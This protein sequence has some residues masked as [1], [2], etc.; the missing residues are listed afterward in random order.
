MT[1]VEN[2]PA[3]AV[4][5]SD[6]TVAED[7]A[8][9]VIGLGPVFTDPDLGLGDALTYTLTVTEP[10]DSLV[11]QVSQSSYT[12]LHQDLQYTH[13]GDN[14]GLGG[15]E[16]DLAREN[17]RSYFAGLGLQTT[18]EPFTYN[19]QTY[20]NVVGVH[21]GVTPSDDIYLVGAHY[22]SVN[23]PGAD[24]NASGTA[25]VMELARVLCQYSF[26]A[27]LVFVAFDREEQGLYG[28][29]AYVA[30]HN[31]AQVKG[32]LS[33]DMIAYNPAGDN[34]DKVRFYDYNGVGSIK[35]D[36]AA[37]FASYSGGLAT[38][39]SNT[40]GGSDHRPFEQAGVDAALV[41][42]YNVWTNPYYH[43]A[44]DAVETA[45]NIDYVYATQV[46]RGVLG[47]LA[48]AAGCARP[49]RTADGHRQRPG[50]DAG[51][52]RQQPRHRGRS[53]PRHGHGWACT[54]KT[55]SA[56]PSRRSTMPPCWTTP[57]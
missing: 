17:I 23:N 24:D 19:S 36:L 25:A 10:V 26:D 56:S 49:D 47:Y 16:H 5:L 21:P 27:T 6:V 9:T 20:Y 46:T 51:L 33:L 2:P 42:E 14:R 29:Y 22:D 12:T 54:P 7:A 52:R 4:P 8:D 35:S 45:G 28:S 34:H 1:D 41:I 39:D 11:A 31:P 38:L 13:A 40:L 44:T 37:A 30:A 55:R 32:M 48:T 53:G 3:V 50:L 57:A 18:L 15:W 43:Q